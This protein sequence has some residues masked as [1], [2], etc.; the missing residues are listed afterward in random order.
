MN[1]LFVCMYI[2]IALIDGVA[3]LAN[4]DMFGERT[5]DSILSE[6][7][8]N[9]VSKKTN[10]TPPTILRILALLNLFKKEKGI[11][12]L[13]LH[14]DLVK[15]DY[16]ILQSLSRTVHGEMLQELNKADNNSHYVPPWS[17]IPSSIKIKYCLILE[18]KA[19]SVGLPIYRC[20]KYWAA[21]RLLF[22]THKR[23]ANR[24]SMERSSTD[25]SFS[26]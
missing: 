13:T 8:E 23:R 1:I 11:T 10:V 5:I 14:H 2:T 24:V 12:N 19:W 17:R 9:F 6:A 15:Q 20:K 4:P 7:K 22:E 26:M 16:K 3:P 21:D 18:R 25:N